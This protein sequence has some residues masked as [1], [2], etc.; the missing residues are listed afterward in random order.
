MRLS[1]EFGKPD[2]LTF[3]IYEIQQSSDITYRLYD[4]DRPASAGRALHLQQSADVS[5]YEPI[6]QHITTPVRYTSGKD[7]VNVLAACRYFATTR[8]D[9]RGG[10]TEFSP[11]N[12]SPHLLTV[13][14]GSAMLSTRGGEIE[15][16]KCASVVVPAAVEDYT[17]EPKGAVTFLISM[18]PDLE[19]QVV[20]P[21]QTMGVTDERIVQ[22]GGHARR[23]DLRTALTR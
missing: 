4:W 6:T 11:A 21:L 5:D 2:K 13:L 20:Q 16:D 15:I 10:V 3:V 17:I 14:D 19:R 9:L 12:W 22:L 8:Y 18:V 23:S 1:L 7:E